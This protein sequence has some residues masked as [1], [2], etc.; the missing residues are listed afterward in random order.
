MSSAQTTVT[1]T[2]QTTITPHNQQPFVTRTYPSQLELDT[3]IRR[4]SLAQNAWA[5]VPLKDRIAIGTKFVV[6]YL[7]LDIMSQLPS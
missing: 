2:S 3:A 5:R 1:D 7:V 4:A 6:S